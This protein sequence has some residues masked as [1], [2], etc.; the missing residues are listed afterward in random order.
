M[1]VALKKLLSNTYYIVLVLLLGSSAIVAAPLTPDEAFNL[2]VEAYTFGYPLVV[3]DVEKSN[4]KKYSLLRST[5]RLQRTP[6][7]PQAIVAAMDA[8]TFFNHLSKLLARQKPVPADSA[9]LKKL[10]RLGIYPG[11]PFSLRKYRAAVAQEI[12]LSVPY[13]QQQ[14]K[15]IQKKKNKK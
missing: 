6:S 14:L 8:T 5:N 2:G 7:S 10:A 1:T 12:K 3:N 13:A 11:R 4:T 15:K 9:T